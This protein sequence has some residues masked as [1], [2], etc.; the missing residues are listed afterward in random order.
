MLCK[1]HLAEHVEFEKNQPFPCQAV[2]YPHPML[3]GGGV[4]TTLLYFLNPLGWEFKI[5]QAIRTPL[6]NF[7]KLKMDEITF[8]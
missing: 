4:E 7:K 1:G 5:L 3:M 8:V 6:G 2:L